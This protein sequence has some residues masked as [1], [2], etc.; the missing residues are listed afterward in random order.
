M[1]TAP[2]AVIANDRTKLI[3]EL[4]DEIACGNNFGV[5]DAS[6]FLD[7]LI[8]DQRI[9]SDDVAILL[10]HNDLS[11]TRISVEERLRK[12]VEAAAVEFFTNGRGAD[13]VDERLAEERADRDEDERERLRG[14]A[15]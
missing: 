2:L 7:T 4:A 1:D 15:A 6:F 3:A 12:L 13:F 8:D 14:Y 11:D 10:T 5:Y 9:T